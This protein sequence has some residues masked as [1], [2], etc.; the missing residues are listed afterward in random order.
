[1]ETKHQF[2]GLREELRKIVFE[3]DTVA[4]KRFDELLILAILASVAVVLLDSVAWVRADWGE[5]IQGDEWLFTLLFSAEYLLRL[6]TVRHPWRYV[7]SFYGLIDLAA[8]LPSFIALLVPGTQYLLVIRML[9]VV[10]LFR[11]LKL[12]QHLAEAQLL[13]QALKASKRK[14]QVFL[15]TVSILVVLLGALMYMIEGEE[16]GYSS[17]PKAM[18][19][20]VVTLTTVGYGDISPKT[21]L[22]QALASFVMIL[23]YAIIAVP[24][25]IVTAEISQARIGKPSTRSCRKCNQERH[26]QDARFCKYCGTA[27]EQT[28]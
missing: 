8:I 24:T 12:T 26:D 6:Y 10:R 1:M 19:W 23:G 18:Y 22:G 13:A 2:K 7:F 4:G 28:G 16:N 11:I 20:A 27:F 15:L 3:A 14:I 21:P 25:G 9:R 17:I 5:G